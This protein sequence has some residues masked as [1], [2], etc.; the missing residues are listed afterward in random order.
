[1]EFR[2][3]VNIHV[4]Y[5]HSKTVFKRNKGNISFGFGLKTIGNDQS[6]P[7]GFQNLKSLN[8]SATEGTSK[9]TGKNTEF[10]PHKS[11]FLL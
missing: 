10:Q 3:H 5:M 9:T 7:P 11:R 2:I 8:P 1:M 6:Q 4:T